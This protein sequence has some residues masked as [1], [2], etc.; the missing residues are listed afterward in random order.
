MITKGW[1]SDPGANDREGT[2]FFLIGCRFYHGCLA[3]TFFLP[4]DQGSR[5]D[6]FYLWNYYGRREG[7][8]FERIFVEILKCLTISRFIGKEF[9]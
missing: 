6:F 7:E 1:R 3:R 9:F 8:S 2:E 5:A 4:K